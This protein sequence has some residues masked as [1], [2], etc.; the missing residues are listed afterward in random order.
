MTALSKIVDILSSSNLINTKVD[1]WKKIFYNAGLFDE[2]EEKS[3]EFETQVERYRV[4]MMK[5][6]SDIM[7]D[8]IMH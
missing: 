2:Y 5:K 7:I 3:F 6:Y 8:V 1:I 4:G